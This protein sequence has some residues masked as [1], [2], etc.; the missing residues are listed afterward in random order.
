MP[1]YRVLFHQGR[2]MSSF[3][4]I[5][6]E[7]LLRLIGVPHGPALIDVRSAEDHADDP[8]IIPGAIR[9]QNGQ[10]VAE[11]VAAWLRHVGVRSAE[12]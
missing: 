8:G 2:T 9:R 1:K 11:G 5:S 4:S 10:S 12:S 3:S 7:K 6:T